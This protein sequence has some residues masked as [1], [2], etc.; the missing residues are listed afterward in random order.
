M[1]AILVGLVYI[2]ALSSY[3][4]STLVFWTEQFLFPF[5]ATEELKQ[6]ISKKNHELVLLK[7]FNLV[8]E[9][10]KESRPEPP[11]KPTRVHDIKYAG[12]DVVSKLSFLRSQ[13]GEN[14]C[15]A[16]V[17]SMLDEVAWLLNMVKTIFSSII[18]QLFSID[19]NGSCSSFSWASNWV[20][21]AN[22]IT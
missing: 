20:P 8:D 21:W 12:A 19:S 5:D 14:N 7:E 1:C 11:N 10:W 9:I 13:L 3:V 22:L 16:I 18:V 15:T 17:V 2:W 6:E 4:M